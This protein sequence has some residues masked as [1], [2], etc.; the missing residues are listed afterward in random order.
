MGPQL[1]Q[2]AHGLFQREQFTRPCDAERYATAQTGDILH[3]TERSPER[4][5]LL[6]PVFQFPDRIEPS[7][8]GAVIEERSDEPIA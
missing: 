5:A 3:I 1:R 7:L 8:N 2:G 4:H 6:N